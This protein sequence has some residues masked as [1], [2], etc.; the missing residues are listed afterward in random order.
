MKTKFLC[1][2]SL[3]LL[4]GCAT[5]FAQSTSYNREEV[6]ASGTIILSSAKVYSREAL[7]DERRKDLAWIDGLISKS[8][9]AVFAPT[10][11]RETEQSTSF[12]A[13]LG[14]NVDP[15]AG[16]AVRSAQQRAA[17]EQQN[18]LTSLMIKRDQLLKDREIFTAGLSEQT[19]P[20]NTGINLLGEGGETSLP[21]A[22]T[23]TE[24][25]DQ[26]IAQLDKA[27]QI[28]MAEA[29]ALPAML[30]YK[31]N[32]IDDFRDR[33]A[34]RGILKAARNAAALDDLHDLNGAR[35]LRL[36]FQATVIPQERFI[37]H[38]G[39]IELRVLNPQDS[40]LNSLVSR[41]I[42]YLNTEK[43]Y[44]QNGGIDQSFSTD[45]I[46]TRLSLNPMLTRQKI[47]DREFILPQR[48]T[49]DP[50]FAQF[51]RLSQFPPA[52]LNATAEA[53]RR[54][55]TGDPGQARLALDRICIADP[56]VSDFTLLYEAGRFSIDYPE[57]A[58][59]IQQV[60][61]SKSNIYAN[62]IPSREF[63]FSVVQSAQFLG[64]QNCVD[65]IIAGNLY[66]DALKP[67]VDEMKKQPVQIYDIGPKEQV[68]QVSSTARSANS[69][70]LAASI[71]ASDPSSGVSGNAALR[72]A[73]TAAGRAATI[74][75]V[76]TVV[77]YALDRSVIAEATKDGSRVP[78]YEGVDTKDQ[79][80][81]FG[82]VI[83][84]QAIVNPK[85]KIEL[86][87]AV[88]TYDLTADISIP[89]WWSDLNFEVRT[90]WAPNSTSLSSGQLTGGPR[91][92][93]RTIAIPAGRAAENF[94]GLSQFFA[95]VK[96]IDIDETALNITD[97]AINSCTE[98][99]FLISGQEGLWRVSK[100]MI[101]GQIV[102]GTAIQPAPDMRGIMVTIPK[103]PA[104]PA[105]RE[106][107]SAEL[108]LF[109]PDQSVTVPTQ[110]AVIPT[111]FGKACTAEAD[112]TATVANDPDAP[113]IK[114]VDNGDPHK[115]NIP[116]RLEFSLV[117]EKM[118]SL[119]KATLGGV[120]GTL[121][122]AKDGKSAKVNF[123]K[124][125]SEGIA[126]GRDIK[127]IVSTDKKDVGTYS[128]EITRSGS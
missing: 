123:T 70:A 62:I 38:L 16:D 101:L 51:I 117:G 92:T 52:Y 103:L 79:G 57:I 43:S 14:I 90:S 77:G 80:E 56:S 72:F 18:A 94:Q 75:R 116:A 12:G 32:P 91:K 44:R 11:A 25:F 83:G 24:Q 41:W 60:V 105:L 95:N 33:L 124:E 67:L 125:Q 110:L 42:V 121:S 61:D 112:G 48:I 30:D 22:P 3:F 99:T 126:S 85:G 7:I 39:A 102:D 36:N 26:A 19:D 1:I 73:R 64:S 23:S 115:R 2:A 106:L 96:T 49:T 31:T 86:E 20:A 114:K 45:G 6:D 128:V 29:G 37:S 46:V 4:N 63:Y 17:L 111:P 100:A 47:A 104:S 84:P 74:E 78:K 89:G 54:S 27:I 15:L 97:G 50:F 81:V 108:I 109:T 59:L 118:G 68:Q 8:G 113:S 87:Q 122:V 93:R 98:T 76:P 34:Y 5:P 10:L 69:L 13:A 40:E 28:K 82:W 66:A 21:S 120:A 119:T 107:K 55:F 53:A 71:A 127:L 35:L 58:S 88:R 65:Q 9:E